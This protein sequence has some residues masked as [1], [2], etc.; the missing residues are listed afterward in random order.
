[1]DLPARPTVRVLK[2]LT[3]GWTDRSQR[4]AIEQGLIKSLLP[5]SELGHPLLERAVADTAE[6][7]GAPSGNRIIKCVREA[8][9]EA[10]LEIKKP[11]TEWRGAVAYDEDGTPWVVFATDEG[12]D[13]FY[14]EVERAVRRNGTKPYMPDEVD[15]GYLQLERSL[16]VNRSWQVANIARA[17]DCIASAIRDG[18]AQ[19][20]LE[21][22]PEDSP[23]VCAELHVEIERLDE[24]GPD[25]AS[26]H[27]EEVL[28]EAYLTFTR[29]VH[30]RH[31]ELLA[32]HLRA[33]LNPQAGAWDPWVKP[34]GTVMYNATISEARLLQLY[35]ASTAAD[36]YETSALSGESDRATHAHYTLRRP[37]AEAIVLGKPVRAVCG[38]WFVPSQDHDNLPVCPRC[39]ADLPIVSLVHRLV[40]KARSDGD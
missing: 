5:L 36:G 21:S 39:E 16:L 25:I 20:Q 30:R 9:E 23:G 34:D 24:P 6:G 40:K 10:W 11:G 19:C 37:L 8:T 35:A 22:H 4:A 27:E 1:M 29:P 15:Y 12:H 14:S 2:K 31:E 38:T 28:V 26:A 18:S 32:S 7:V 17:V 3:K 33:L 13:S